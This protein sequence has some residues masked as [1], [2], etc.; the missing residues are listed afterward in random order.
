[1][2][3]FFSRLDISDCLSIY[4]YTSLK[5]L[6]MKSNIIHSPE[7]VR[8]F[9]ESYELSHINTLQEI[10][11]HAGFKRLQMTMETK[12]VLGMFCLRDMGVQI[13]LRNCESLYMIPDAADE[14]RN[15]KLYRII[16]QYFSSNHITIV[17]QHEYFRAINFAVAKL[18][19]KKKT[20]T[21]Y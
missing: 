8:V 15:F 6:E 3:L 13:Y 5:D 16:Q 11:I 2:D 9:Y 19:V 4:T 21:V 10:Y 12:V 18:A 20:L 14:L 17:R 7:A 1:M